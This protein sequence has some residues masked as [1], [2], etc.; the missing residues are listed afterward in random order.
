MAELAL[1]LVDWPAAEALAREALTL[2]EDIGRQEE[3]ARDC[4]RLAKALARQGRKEEG[5]P[6]ARRAV[7]IF[8]KLRSPRLEEAREV[9]RECEEKDERFA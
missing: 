5:L 1:D 2:A 3:I 8:T 9:L 7:E 6:Y 4:S